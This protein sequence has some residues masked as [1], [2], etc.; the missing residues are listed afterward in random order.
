M[1]PSFES[2]SA[3][4]SSQVNRSFPTKGRLLLGLT[5]RHL[6]SIGSSAMSA[7]PRRGASGFHWGSLDRLQP[8]LTRYHE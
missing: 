2:D 7:L 1:K 4:A 8:V 5:A 3:S 6:R